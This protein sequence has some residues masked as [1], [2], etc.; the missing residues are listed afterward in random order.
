MKI[1]DNYKLEELIISYQDEIIKTV[2]WIEEIKK[3]VNITD[4]TMNHVKLYIENLQ[5]KMDLLI[6][7]KNKFENCIEQLCNFSDISRTE[8][9]ATKYRYIY[10]MKIDD[11][12]ERL[13]ISRRTLYRYLNRCENV[14]EPILVSI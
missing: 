5:R 9:L 13:N 7:Q 8:Y 14:L 12:I 11:I 4:K 2:D 10:Q 1:T 3:T 6:V